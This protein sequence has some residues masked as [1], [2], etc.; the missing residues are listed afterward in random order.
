MNTVD[1]AYT[2][3]TIYSE[4]G[5][6]SFRGSTVNTGKATDDLLSVNTRRDLG[7]DNSVFELQLVPRNHWFEKIRPNDLV[8]IQMSRKSK[9]KDT[10]FVGL[11]D[12]IRLNLSANSNTT[13]ITGRGFSK[14]LANFE[15]GVLTQLQADTSVMN[16]IFQNILH[17]LPNGEVSVV[18]IIRSTFY[19]VFLKHEDYKF[20][21]GSTYSS[22]VDTRLSC[23][24]EATAIKM[25][26]YA[27][28]SGNY[29]NLLRELK[30]EPYHE[31]FWEIYNSKPTMVFRPTPFDSSNWNSLSRKSID[32]EDIVNT[33]VGISDLETYTVYSLKYNGQ[34]L[35]LDRVVQEAL[36]PP[37]Y[38]SEYYKKYGLKALTVQVPYFRLMT[39][40]VGNERNTMKNLQQKLYD[41]YIKNNSMKN[42][43]ITIIGD[44][45]FKIG[46]RLSLWKEEF[47]IEAVNHKFICGQSYTTELSVTRGCTNSIRFGKP[48][49]TCEEYSAEKILAISNGG[50]MR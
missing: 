35:P 44:P 23:I 24:P 34:E 21:N 45:T 28:Y 12:D 36:A 43:S 37:I 47:Y 13:S 30:G 5:N 10:V 42:G 8:I 48:V 39:S 15:I 6:L 29:F 17:Q 26:N 25:L 46:T 3:V 14:A 16:P 41:W 1:I 19:N 11:V 20:S 2:T 9:G 27:Q 50:F 49:G 40:S 7:T 18:D 32:T 4:T 38:N 33:S 31:L 22:M